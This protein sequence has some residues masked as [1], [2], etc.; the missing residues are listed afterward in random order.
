[1][2]MNVLLVLLTAL[3]GPVVVLFSMVHVRIREKAYYATLLNSAGSINS[4]RAP[5]RLR[6]GVTTPAAPPRS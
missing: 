2:F 6:P 3:L 4:P 1:M 5:L